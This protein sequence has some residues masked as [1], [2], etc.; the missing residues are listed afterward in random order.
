MLRKASLLV[1]LGLFLAVVFGY[2]VA[3]LFILRYEQG[4]VYPPYSSLRA[5]PMG[6]KGVY[7]ALQ[8]MPGV[9]VRQNFKPLVKLQPETPVTLV[10]AGVARYAMWEE[11]EVLAFDRIV[12]GGSRAI[13][14]FSPIEHSPVAKEILRQEKEE[15]DRKEKKREEEKKKADDKAD[16]AGNGKDRKDDDDEESDRSTLVKFD[17]VGKR[18]GVAFDFLPAAED[19]QFKRRAVLQDH[20]SNLEPELSWH[21]A[22]Y[23]KDLKPEW[24]V[25]YTCD[26]QAVVIERPYGQGSIVLAAD[27]FFLSNEAMRAERR[28]KL[29]AWLFK[30]PPDLVFDEEHHDVRENPGIA[31]LARKYRLHGAVAGLALLAFLFVWKNS[32]RFLPPMEGT[33]GADDIVLG[34]ESGEGFVN[35]LRRTIPPSRIL[36]VC[37][38]EWHKAF[39]HKPEDVEKVAQLCAQELARPSRERNPVDAYRAMTRA[40]SRQSKRPANS[41]KP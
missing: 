16:K 15:K 3:R 24:K 6:V 41:P 13:F 20:G 25:L 40:V 29:L 22:L 34:K 19:Q 36:E 39:A 1:L 33:G 38:D 31:S 10:Y 5:D 4:D 27:S 37:A 9:A 23:F 8:Q 26:N 11:K 2:G 35:L 18:W 7:S 17:E 28:P 12:L 30:G 14:T 21:S 32:V